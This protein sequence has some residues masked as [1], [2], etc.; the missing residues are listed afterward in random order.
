VAPA[1][2]SHFSSWGLAFMIVKSIKKYFLI[3]IGS[4]SLAFGIVGIFIPVLPTTPFLLLSS[5]CFIHSSKRLYNW[6]INHKI[7][8]EYIY[9]YMTY[10]AV[11]RSTKIGALLFLWLSLMISMLVVSSLHLRIFLFAV[12]IGVSIHLYTLK[13]LNE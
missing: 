9:N 7:F 1:A 8:G 13:T 2:L 3:F 10:R 6:L 11:K 4:L 12:G 5:F